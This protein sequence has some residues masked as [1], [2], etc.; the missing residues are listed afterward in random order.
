MEPPLVLIIE[1]N[2]ELQS[3]YKLKFDELAV[4]CHQIADGQEG[5]D[6][7]K[8][9]GRYDIVILDLMLPHVSGYDLLNFIRTTP[10]HAPVLV[11]SAITDSSEPLSD[12]Q[13]GKIIHIP[14]G[15]IALSEVID[16]IKSYLDSRHQGQTEA[17]GSAE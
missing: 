2:P 9:G 7:L 13:P 3:L 4:D 14:K 15:D 11:I 17:S 6:Y 12:L 10:G 5:L 16:K 8:S 1:D